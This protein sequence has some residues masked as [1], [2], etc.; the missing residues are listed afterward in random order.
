MVYAMRYQID[1]REH[2][3]DRIHPKDNAPAFLSSNLVIPTHRMYFLFRSKGRERA[4]GS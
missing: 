4:A 1:N 2:L 3:E